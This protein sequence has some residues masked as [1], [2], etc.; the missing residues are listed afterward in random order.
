MDRRGRGGY[1][2]DVERL[3]EKLLEKWG[4]WAVCLDSEGDFPVETWEIE[5]KDGGCKLMR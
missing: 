4:M 2:E 1:K 5:E 3:L